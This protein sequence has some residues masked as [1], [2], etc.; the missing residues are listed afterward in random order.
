MTPIEDALLLEQRLTE[1]GHQ[2]HTLITYPGLGH[3]FYPEDYYGIAMGPIQEYVLSDLTAWLKDPAR[4]VM[5]LK[6]DLQTAE[7][8]LK[9]LQDQLANEQTKISDLE[10]QVEEFQSTLDLAKNLAYIS[11]GFT[12]IAVI[13]ILL[14]V[15]QRR[16]I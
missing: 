12:I 5:F 6:E 16:I 14:L 10:K 3:Y 4:K 11:L 8:T 7:D 15:F 13:A 1:R 2:D 9:N